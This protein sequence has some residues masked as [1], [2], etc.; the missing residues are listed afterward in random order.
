MTIKEDAHVAR[1]RIAT[2]RAQVDVAIAELRV[3]QA[4]CGHPDK[5][6]RSTR[7]EMG[8]YCPDCGW[9]T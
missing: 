9:D 5:Y 8:W 4:G 1:K 6:K 7:G 3:V 2:L